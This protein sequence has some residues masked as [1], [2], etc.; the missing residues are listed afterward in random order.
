MNQDLDSKGLNLT[1]RRFFQE[2]E[3]KVSKSQVSRWINMKYENASMTN[4][5]LTKK[6][7]WSRTALISKKRRVSF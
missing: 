4:K 6:I 2:T 3:I 7:R 1:C 5:L